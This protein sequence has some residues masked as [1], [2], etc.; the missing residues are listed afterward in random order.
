[1]QLKKSIIFVVIFGLVGCFGPELK[2]V[3]LKIAGVG[4]D[5]FTFKFAN[6]K[7]DNESTHSAFDCGFSTYVTHKDA[8]AMRELKVRAEIHQR[9]DG[10][11]TFCRLLDHEEIE[12]KL[13]NR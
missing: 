3:T 11:V 1:M 9:V 2:P 7:N 6:P 4:V 10:V 12:D 13:S 8:V 5:K